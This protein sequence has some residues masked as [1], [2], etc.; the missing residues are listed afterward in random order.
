MA[1][2]DNHANGPLVQL[3]ITSA[4]CSFFALGATVYRLYKRRGRFG[5]DD[6]WALF[7]LVALIIQV[8][9]VFLH[10]PLPNTL[11]NT[12]R[13]AVY[14]LTGTTF[15]LIIWAS[16]LSILFS[17]VRIEPS[18]TRRK[19]LFWISATF[20]ASALFLVGQLFWLC[21]ANPSW[22]SF[23]SPHAQCELPQQVAISQIVTDVISD[24]ILLL[25]PLPLFRSLRD[26]SLNHKLTLMFSTC[27]VTTIVSLV[28]AAFILKDYDMKILISAIVEACLSL[29]V[30][31]IPVVITTTI[32]VV[33]EPDHAQNG[34]TVQFSSIFWFS[35]AQQTGA[36]ELHT[37]AKESP[38]A[39]KPSYPQTPENSTWNQ[40]NLPARER[41][42]IGCPQ[43]R[44]FITGPL[45]P[46]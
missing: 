17:I 31:N 3:K 38:D 19:L 25:A 37:I 29:I 8:V 24:S 28:H 12:T 45:S 34:E 42:S 44:V 1:D 30:A 43:N 23:K 46:I 11:S 10:I 18:A 32:D 36:M 4:T 39:V 41:L 21:E 35:E 2:I 5:A 40:N 20:V 22:K 13:I 27:V 9:A 14:Y 6:L 33:G 7:A 26:K 16:R 15:C